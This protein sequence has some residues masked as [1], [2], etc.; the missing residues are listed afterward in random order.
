ML[1]KD[2]INEINEQIKYEFFSS[3]LYLAM[4]AYSAENDLPGFENWFLVQAEEE[5]FHAM[6]FY[7][8]L[9]EKGERVIIKGFETPEN[10]YNSLKEVFE[11]SLEH[12]KFVTSRIYKLMDI[13][14]GERE[15]STISMLNW[16]IDEQVEEESSFGYILAQLKR[17]GEN[18]DGIYRLDQELSQRVF[19]PPTEK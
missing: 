11:K 7:N 18:S 14:Q 17:M 10:H 6:K 8:F 1:S 16:F 2:L 19:T 13:A 9:N 3:H 4:A 5:R 12:E 15:Y